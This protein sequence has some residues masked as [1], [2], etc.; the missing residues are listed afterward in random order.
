MPSNLPANI[1][2]HKNGKGYEVRLSYKDLLS[3][4]Q[5]RVSK[6]ARTLNEARAILRELSQELYK[7]GSVAAGNHL[8]GDWASYWASDILPS[9]ELKQSTQ[10][11]YINLLRSNLQ[12]STLWDKKLRAI[13]SLDLN[14]YFNGE[15]GHLAQQTRR[16]L[17]TIVSHVFESAVQSRL[18]FANPIKDGVQRPK[19]N[20][21]QARFPLRSEVE[22]IIHKLD[23]SKYRGALELIAITG[24]RRGEALGL[25]WNDIDLEARTLRVEAS[26]NDGG[27]RSTPKSDKS[28]RTLDLTD[29]AIRI[30]QREGEIQSLNQTRLGDAWTGNPAGFVFTSDDGSALNPRNFLRVV[31]R[32]ASSAGLQNHPLGDITVHSF[33]H[34]VATELLSKGVEIFVVS[35]ILGHESIQTT[36]DLYGHLLD[37][38]RKRALSLL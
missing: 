25:T 8:F 5:R 24:L 31:K 37:E 35:R 36:V 33:R 28:M 38:S 34:Y 9:S 13:T 15:L 14:K 23:S 7:R 27:I 3:G 21:K 22:Q 11:L 10:T 20:R 2:R 18:L 17:Y 1:R 12:N 30:L 16:N 19:R 26:L 4:E 32:A 6:S 29:K